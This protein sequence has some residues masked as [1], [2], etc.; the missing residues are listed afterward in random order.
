M[1]VVKVEK[2]KHGDPNQMKL[3]G[4]VCIANRG[5]AT[6]ENGAKTPDDPDRCDYEVELQSPDGAKRRVFIQHW[7]RHG[8]VTLVAK[9][10][11]SLDRRR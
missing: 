3:L 10:L 7:R 2:W 1:I 8:W 6:A 9:A 4:V 11:S 5:P